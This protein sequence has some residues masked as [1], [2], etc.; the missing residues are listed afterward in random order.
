[1]KLLGVVLFLWLIIHFGRCAKILGVF[2]IPSVSHYL[3]YQ[4]IY[5]ELAIRGHD[6]TVITPTVLNNS[7]LKNLKE[8]DVHQIYD[9]WKKY[10]I[11]KILSTDAFTYNLVLSVHKIARISNEIVLKDI[12]VQDLIK[13]EE[14]FDVIIVEGIY[15]LTFALAA[16]FRVPIIGKYW[17]NTFFV[18]FYIK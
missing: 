15:P 9:V 8:I 7:S 13:S 2:T 18:L 4:V 14:T 3:I 6:V 11:S 17:F 10:D 5:K 16:R 12:K 1:M